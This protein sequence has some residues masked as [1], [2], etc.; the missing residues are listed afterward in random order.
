MAQQLKS[1]M[2]GSLQPAVTPGD[3][4]SS[5]G[6]CGY[7]HA[8]VYGRRNTWLSSENSFGYVTISLLSG[9]LEKERTN[10]RILN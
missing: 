8:H 4:T 3:L 5:S 9:F 10:I 6:L 2:S 1:A 7:T